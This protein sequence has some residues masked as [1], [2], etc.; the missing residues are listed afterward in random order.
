MS[1]S[2]RVFSGALFAKSLQIHTIA[3]HHTAALQRTRFTTAS[4]M[5]YRLP[6]DIVDDSEPERENLRRQEVKQKAAHPAKV[7]IPHVLEVIEITDDEEYDSDH[8]F[9]RVIDLSG[10]LTTFTY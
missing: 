4:T 7:Q 3:I 9:L 5:A 2:F 10:K 6:D 8:K 1:V